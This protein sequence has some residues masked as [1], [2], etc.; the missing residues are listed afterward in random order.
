[1]DDEASY[2]CDSCGEE[3]VVPIDLAAGQEQV[4]VEDCPVCCHPMVIHVEVDD[5]GRASVWGESE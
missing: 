3:I 1:M 4:Y 5:D 2:I